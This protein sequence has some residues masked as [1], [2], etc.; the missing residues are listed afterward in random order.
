M[1]VLEDR[2]TIAPGVSMPRVGFGTYQIGGSD[3][4]RCTLHAL[5]LGYRH[6]DTAQVYGNEAEVG[7]AIRDS[8]VPRSEIF[9][10]TKLMPKNQGAARAPAAIDKS[11]AKLDIE[12][13]D[14]FLI[15][16]PGTKHRSS[17]PKNAALRLESWRALEDALSAA[18]VRAIGVSNY[19]EEHLAELLAACVT[20]P[21]V[22]QFEAHVMLTQEPLRAFCADKQ[23]TVVSYSTLGRGE[24]LDN[25]TVVQIAADVGATP[26]QV[27][28]RWALDRDMLV[29]PKSVSEARIES[30]A[31][32]DMAL[33][34]EQLRRL[35]ACHADHRTCWD[36]TI[37]K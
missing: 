31:Q 37:V 23:V 16:W 19:T 30:N 32:L 10:T 5:R 34:E 35:D 2:V 27:V 15:H 18:K 1:G 9:V 33:S 6:I 14:L 20:R 4:Y 7:A 11:L 28:L 25:E 3:A 29:I 24:A 22:N 12:Y 13:V 8:G 21:A 26:A 36:P 17:S